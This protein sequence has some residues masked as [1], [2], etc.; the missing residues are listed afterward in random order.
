MDMQYMRITVFMKNY[1]NFVA[2]TSQVWQ[3]IEIQ[4]HFDVS[5]KQFII[6]TIYWLIAIGHDTFS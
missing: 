5:L 2:P 3:L 4:M 1:T 6:W